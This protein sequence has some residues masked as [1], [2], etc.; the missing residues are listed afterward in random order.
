M[1][2]MAKKV[3]AVLALAVCGAL[4]AAAPAH[5]STDD[6]VYVVNLSSGRCLDAPAQANTAGTPVQL[7][8][9]YPP[10]QY[11]QMWRVHWLTDN[12]F[13]LRNVAS[14][15]C[16]DSRDWGTA[17]GTVLQLWPCY[18]V[19]HTNQLWK[20]LSTATPNAWWLQEQHSYKVADAVW[21]QIGRNGTRVQLWYLIGD[22]TQKNQR[23]VFKHAN[24]F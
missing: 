7:W 24:E 17:E 18:D 15:L 19:T 22:E 21:Q 2:I 9:C 4:A 12:S 11:N 10:T 1:R 6:V 14:D 8:D 16:L 13:Q 5:A 23:W 20:K 3:G